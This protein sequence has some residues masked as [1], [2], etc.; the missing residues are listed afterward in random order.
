MLVFDEREKLENPG[1]KLS[2]QSKVENQQ[3]Q[4]TYDII[5]DNGWQRSFSVYVF[6]LEFWAKY[7]YNYWVQI[8]FW[9]ISKK[10]ACG[11]SFCN[12]S[13]VNDC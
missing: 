3:T 1:K 5:F 2:E 13:Q 10:L 11:H 12:V 9:T 8:R 4:S 7:M 6:S